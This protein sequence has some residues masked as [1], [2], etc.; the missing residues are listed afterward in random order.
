MS[1]S[2]G[3]ICFTSKR[4][5]RQADKH[6]SEKSD[7]NKLDSDCTLPPDH[8]LPP[9]QLGRYSPDRDYYVQAAERL[10]KVWAEHQKL[11]RHPKAG[12]L[13]GLKKKT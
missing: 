1:R 2:A 9:D 12:R 4:V 3:G 8:P 6:M 5:T 13:M 7:H 11:P 10:A